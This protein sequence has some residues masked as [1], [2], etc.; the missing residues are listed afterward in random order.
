M[1]HDSI[2]ASVA[3]DMRLMMQAIFF[4]F[5]PQIDR[6]ARVLTHFFLCRWDCRKEGSDKPS[7]N[8]QAHKAEVNCVAFHPTYEWILAT[9]SG[10]KVRQ[11]Q[12]NLRAYY[13]ILTGH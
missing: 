5:K 12:P 3:D 1:K 6:H 7:H 8:I 11:S 4:F 2:F 13:L 10:D 9:G